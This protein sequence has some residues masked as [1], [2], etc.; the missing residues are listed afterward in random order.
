MNFMNA[1]LQGDSWKTTYRTSGEV[2][3]EYDARTL[4]EKIAYAAWACADPGVQFDSTI[5]KW[6]TCKNT[7]RIN[8]SNPCSEYLFLD[9][10]ACNLASINL[11]KFLRD[12]DSFDIEGFRAT[13]RVFVT[14]MEIIVS[15]S[16]YP[17]KDIAQRSDEYRPLGLGYANL[18]ALLMRLGIPYDSDQACAY[19]GA[20]TAILS[21]HG[22]HTSAEIAESIGAFDGHKK[23]RDAM[24]DVMRLH[25][26]A[27]YDIDPMACPSDLFD[28]AKA[29]WDVCVEKGEQCGY[30][31]SQISVIAPT[32]TISFLMD[33]DTTGIGTGICTRQVQEVG[34]RRIHEDCQPERSRCPTQLRLHAPADRGDY[35]VHCR[36]KV[37][38][39]GHR[40]ST[41]IH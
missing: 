1:Y 30:R 5:Q 27:A 23:N 11:A 7:G 40:T 29:D 34:G 39:K 8:A 16:S 37:L 31:N 32:G 6:H 12:D 24:L 19:A 9:D 3:D 18:G 26:D 28:A 22:Y 14:A 33:C 36:N 17:T 35:Y 25:R 20:I 41:P 10:S 4:I 2:A 21:G 38:L 13:V 15:L